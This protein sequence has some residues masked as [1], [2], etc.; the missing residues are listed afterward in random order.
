MVFVS[1]GGCPG[2]GSLEEADIFRDEDHPWYLVIECKSCTWSAWVLEEDF[3][4]GARAAP[5]D[6]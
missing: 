3:D 2:C 4:K 1:E 6:R 5:S